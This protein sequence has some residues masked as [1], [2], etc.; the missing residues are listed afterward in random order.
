LEKLQPHRLQ[1]SDFRLQVDLRGVEAQAMSASKNDAADILSWFSI[2]VGGASLIGVTHLGVQA[3]WFGRLPVEPF[4]GPEVLAAA[5]AVGLLGAVA[6][7][8][9][10]PCAP[11]R[12]LGLSG[13]VFNMLT[14]TLSIVVWAAHP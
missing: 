14:V 9:A 11:R 6:G 7:A 12:F 13:A 5:V 2:L 8:W 1:T 4:Q 3:S 10:A